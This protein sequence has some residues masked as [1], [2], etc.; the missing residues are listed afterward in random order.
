MDI[1]I[2]KE[3]E[4]HLGLDIDVIQQIINLQ[5]DIGVVSIHGQKVVVK[6]NVQRG[7]DVKINKIDNF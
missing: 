6:K 2:Q 7:E 1:I 5:Q 3:Q 4:N